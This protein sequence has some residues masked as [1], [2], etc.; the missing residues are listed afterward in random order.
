MNLVL[1]RRDSYL[2]FVKTGVKQDTMNLL[3]NAPLFGYGLFPD[4]AIVTAEQDITKYEASS[5]AQGPGPGVS[6]HIA[7]KGAHR[8]KPFERTE[9]ILPLLTKLTSSNNSHGGNLAGVGP[10]VVAAGGVQ[11]LVFPSHSPL[12]NINDSY[13]ANPT[14]V[15]VNSVRLDSKFQRTKLSR[16]VPSVNSLTV[17]VDVCCPV[18][19]HVP[20]VHSHGPPQK[21]GVRPGHCQNKIKHVKG[22]CCVNPCLSA[23]SV[24]NVPNAVSK[25]NVGGR[26]QSFW[27][28]WQNMGSN[29]RVVYP[30][31]GLHSSL[32]TKA[33]FDKV[34]LD[35]KRLLKSN[36][37]H[38]PK[39]SPYKSHKQ[40]GSRKGGGQVVPGFL[41]PSFSGSQIKQKMEANLRSESSQ[42]IPQHRYLQLETPET[43]RL[44]LKTREWVTSLVT[45]VKGHNDVTELHP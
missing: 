39:G 8:F 1:I 17:S 31:G 18:V 35:S 32:Q 16:T 20:T 44:S 37:E 19:N 33:P 7:W 45:K 23:P 42:F 43:I 6:Q 30:Q 21:K 40:V 38:V 27:Q 10:E 5:V 25:Q 28:V 29:P 12:S 3:R 24:S 15:P 9:N 26:L 34:P 13:C 11:T 41:Q 22:V 14:S 4:A 2:D 36:Q